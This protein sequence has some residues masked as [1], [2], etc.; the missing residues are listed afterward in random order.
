MS[1][2]RVENQRLRGEVVRLIRDWHRGPGRLLEVLPDAT[3]DEKE[4]V[5]ER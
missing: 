3:V 1:E 2:L 4:A 5:R